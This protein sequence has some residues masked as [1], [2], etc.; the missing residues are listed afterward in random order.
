MSTNNI[1][2]DQPPL[3]F[4]LSSKGKDM[5]VDNGYF[6]LV[7]LRNKNGSIIWNCQNRTCAVSLTTSNN[8]ILRPPTEHTCNPRTEEAIAF[9][10]CK[11]KIKNLAA[12]IKPKGTLKTLHDLQVFKTVE[13][14]QKSQSERDIQPNIIRILNQRVKLRTKRC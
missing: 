11:T 1:E 5:L 2:N 14:I 3:K 12:E 9:H 6:Y 7:R 10:E 4:V 8:R 13:K